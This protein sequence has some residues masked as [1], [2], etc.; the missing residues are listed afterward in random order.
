ML[1]GGV[2]GAGG[3][4]TV[5]LYVLA[6]LQELMYHWSAVQEG[7]TCLRNCRGIRLKYW[8]SAKGRLFSLL[9]SY[10]GFLDSRRLFPDPALLKN[11][12]GFCM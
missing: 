9:V 7:I 8:I 10:L 5:T 12:W 4:R 11:L 3:E 1:Y 2:G 6:L